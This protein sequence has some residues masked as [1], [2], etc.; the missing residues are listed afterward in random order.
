MDFVIL[1][2][3]VGAAA[4]GVW[5]FTQRRRPAP[6]E[7]VWVLPPETPTAT[8]GPVV[9]AEP[10]FQVL[11]RDALVNRDRTLDP[12]RWDNTPDD[13]VG[14][15]PDEVAE[16]APQHFDRAWLERQREDRTGS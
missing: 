13:L 5:V 9:D 16:Q 11:D 4:W 1:L 2:L 8:R 3:V 14:T 15:D 6:P 7:D 10:A 12:S